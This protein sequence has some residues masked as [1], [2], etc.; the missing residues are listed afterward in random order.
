MTQAEAVN[1][2]GVLSLWETLI[3]GKLR[4]SSFSGGG[5]SVPGI[6]WGVSEACHHLSTLISVETSLFLSEEGSPTH[7]GHC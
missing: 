6:L 1:A 4:L 3:S 5:V 2:A 7:P